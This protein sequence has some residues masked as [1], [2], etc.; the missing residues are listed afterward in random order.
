MTEIIYLLLVITVDLLT[1]S[2]PVRS[3]P[4]FPHIHVPRYV[5]VSAR[6][7]DMNSEDVT[8]SSLKPRMSDIFFTQPISG[9]VEIAAHF[10]NLYLL[11]PA[12]CLLAT[13][14]PHFQKTILTDL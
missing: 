14:E 8:L 9:I 10:P 3:A 13:R 12:R 1:G 2:H 4:V 7:I 6:Y 5:F 11:S